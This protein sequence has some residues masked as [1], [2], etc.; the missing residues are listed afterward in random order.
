[1][2]EGTLRIGVLAEHTL[3]EE[4]NKP[5]GLFVATNTP[6]PVGNDVDLKLAL[7][8]GEGMDLHGH[9]EWIVTPAQA[10][11]RRPAGMAVRCDLNDLQRALLERLRVLRPS[12]SR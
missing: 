2:V 3:I 6:Q 12:I 5:C 9:V 11:L 10:T 8:W 1:M 4:D 7:P